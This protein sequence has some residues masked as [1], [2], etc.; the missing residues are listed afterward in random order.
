M[1]ARPLALR[2]KSETTQKN[3]AVPFSYQMKK[4]SKLSRKG[5]YLIL[6]IS[7]RKRLF[8]MKTSLLTKKLHCNNSVKSMTR[9]NKRKKS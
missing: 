9:K 1:W 8:R 7:Q 2:R 3:A 6:K 4:F 5:K